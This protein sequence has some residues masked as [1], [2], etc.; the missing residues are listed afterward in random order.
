MLA[1]EPG[2]LRTT[3]LVLA[4]TA[5]LIGRQLGPAAEADFFHAV[6][7]QEL[8]I[9]TLTSGDLTRIAELVEKYVDVPLGGTD[10]SV[11]AISERHLQTRI[12]TLDRRH[13]A[14]VRPKHTTTFEIV[15]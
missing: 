6:A 8:E 3:A 12:A 4:E 15:P 11:M 13:F 10:A 14:V 7:A 5:Y 9:E 1:A 2:V